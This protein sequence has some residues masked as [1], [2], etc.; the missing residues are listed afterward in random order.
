M[1]I[2]I[3]IHAL[4]NFA[5]CN[6]NSDDTGSP[7]DAEFGGYRR[8]RI[9]SQCAKRAIRTYFQKNEL[10]PQANRGERTKRLAEEVSRRLQAGGR[11]SSDA[12]RVAQAAVSTVLPKSEFK[13]KV[14]KTPYLLFLGDS[15][16]DHFTRLVEEF[17]A[18]FSKDIEHPNS[19][20]EKQPGRGK[21]KSKP[22]KAK[23]PDGFGKA[24]KKLLDGGAA[25]DIALF[26]R[27][28]AD[29]PENSV[30][31]AA[32]VAH[33]I[34]TNTLHT[35]GMDYYTAVDDLKPG[36]AV[37]ADMIGTIAFNS[38]CYYRYANVD[39]DQLTQNLHGD[40]ELT[41]KTVKAFL[42]AFIHA[43]PT[44]KQNL[45]A[46]HQPPS[47]IMMIVRSGPPVSLANA[48]V[49]PIHPKRDGDLVS[50]SIKA[51]DQHYHDL[52]AMYGKGG[53]QQASVVVLGSID[54]HHLQAYRTPQ[55]DEAIQMIVRDAFSSRAS[56]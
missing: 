5:P 53:L 1:P 8:G 3:E 12:D 43:I 18:F 15:E 31:A 37:G 47:F 25:S 56:V 36:T 17:W 21:A 41:Q 52:T 33:A 14:H 44:G 34:S 29:L 22:E 46:A 11:S 51:L 20:N 30:D 42:Q 45:F 24:V 10:I 13:D 28:L 49:K 32:Q 39:L 16:I 38:A 4:Q 26:G 7:K 9:S 40:Q 19:G 55:V 54:L 2:R 23:A 48:F 27:M 35:L 6:L 50:A